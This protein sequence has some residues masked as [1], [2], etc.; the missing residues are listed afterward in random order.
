MSWLASTRTRLRLL[1]AR[2][3]AESRMDEEFRFHLDMETERLAREHSLELEEARR[4][5]L[6][7]FG[8]VERYK[9][10]LRDGRGLAWLGGLSLDFKLGVRMAAKYPGLSLVSVLGM[11]VAIA[12]GALVFGWAAA[13][14]DP[15]LPL[16]GGDR[17]VA[18]QTDRAD[19]PG[20][21]DQ[22]VL[23]D[24]VVWRTALTTVRDLGAFQLGDRNL[25][26]ERGGD[27]EVT[28]VVAVAE[29]SAAGFRVTRVPPLLGRPLV[30]DD[31]RVG[32]PPVLVIGERE[33]QRY[34]GGD[35][36]IIGR[37]VRLGGTVHTVAGVMPEDFRFP[38]NDG[39][40]VPLRL[41]ASAYA[42]GA[43]PPIQVFGR[44]ADGVTFEQ[45]RAQVAA[46]GQRMAAEY[47]ETHE[48]RRPTVVP[49]ARTAEPTASGPEMVWLLYMF[50]LG[51]S[52]LLVVIAANV[53]ALVYARTAAR[54]AEIAVRTALGASR[55]R[56]ITQLFVEALVISAAAAAVGLSLAAF[57]LGWM[58]QLLTQKGQGLPFW[59]HLGLSPG[60][61]A[62]VAGLALVG[63]T[64]VGVV[65]ALKATGRRAYGSLQRFAA[66]GSG[67]KL[68][69][70]WTTLIIVQV[71]IT[72][73]VLPASVHHAS[74]LLGTSM[75]D[76]DYRVEEFLR[77][78]V[79]L[80][81]EEAPSRTDSAEA[82]AYQRRFDARFAN[83]ADALLQRLGSEPGV[84]AAFVSAFPGGERHGRFEIE[85]DAGGRN[86]AADAAGEKTAMRATI[87]SATVGLFELF[88]API[89]AGR[90]FVDADTAEGS[91]A[92][93]VD[94][95]FAAR[96]PGGN[97]LG[98]RIRS[99]GSRRTNSGDGQADRA[100]WLEIVGVVAD[101]PSTTTDPD[102]VALPN[103]YR[104]A[105][106]SGLRADGLQAT[107]ILLRLRVR[108]GLT[109]AFTRR[110][111][112]MVAATDPGLQLHDVRTDA[113]VL[114]S[115]ARELRTFALAVAFATLSV[116]LLSAAGIYAMLSFTVAQR[117]REI[118]I[119]TALGAD[120][121][122]IVSSIV[123]RASAQLGAGVAAG[124]I[125]ALALD[126]A[127]GGMV[128][129]RPSAD[130]VGLRGA[131]VMP[132]VAGIVMAVG[133]LAALGPARRA[134]AVQ[135]TEVLR[136]E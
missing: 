17:I 107:S 130:T 30:D 93:I 99:V 2:R 61:I 54:T 62:Y 6:A 116:L 22:H 97:V 23:H 133:L 37:T 50:Q 52:L 25:V 108:S 15:T 129:G 80:D 92:V 45:A 100:P 28:D 110:L 96:I 89:V 79:S 67:M 91:T 34:F 29:M 49:F 106:P 118:G 123:T 104:A 47:P 94:S 70:T 75:R 7:A 134:L 12:I 31:E 35:P 76:S 124:L 127:T 1:V 27:D 128:I 65:P 43:G 131:V 112:D 87:T 113:E 41:D 64:V 56:V 16:E 81:R 95:A 105:T 119:R 101:P 9:E 11:A 90:G 69:S 83:R 3:A 5:A 136:E 46:I 102:D 84:A 85:G 68:G 74:A 135:P 72:V 51:A 63:G 58:Q 115:G 60:L 59:F 39:F 8:G 71:A 53:A 82:S 73:A 19:A 36:N 114:S 10:E 14:L 13:M 40:W 77:A 26:V 32:G 55:A 42:I 103:V 66:R 122:R 120:H 88:D 132:I 21:F 117:R 121:R 86:A 20:D 33:W 109:P 24:F 38:R 111:R 57:S 125:L 4:R 44:L 98:R 78:R 48:Y 18:V 126:R